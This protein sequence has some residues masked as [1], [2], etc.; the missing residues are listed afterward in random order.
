MKIKDV[1]LLAGVVGAG[2][3][4]WSKWG[5]IT[6]GFGSWGI[7]PSAPVR[8]PET[9]WFVPPS[10]APY[11]RPDLPPGYQGPPLPDIMPIPP[12]SLPELIFPPL[13]LLPH[14]PQEVPF[15][16]VMPTPPPPPTIPEMIF[17]P[18]AILRPVISPT[19][20][21]APTPTY[22][23]SPPTTYDVPKMVPDPR[24]PPGSFGGR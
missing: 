9:P 1:A 22:T 12:P 18:L 13:A 14:V 6:K 20:T 17:P 19:P 15:T 2:V 5:E 8:P 7:G 4:L 23:P 16:P 10:V 21:P 11:I 3:L 24:R